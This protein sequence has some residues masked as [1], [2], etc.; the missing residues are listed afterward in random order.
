M[1]GKQALGANASRVELSKV[2][3]DSMFKAK[4]LAGGNEALAAL[5]IGVPEGVHITFIEDTATMWHFVIPAPPADGELMDSE[6]EHVAGGISGS[7]DGNLPMESAR[8]K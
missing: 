7:G 6:L 4:L 1:T 3:S 2:R 5:G 8:L